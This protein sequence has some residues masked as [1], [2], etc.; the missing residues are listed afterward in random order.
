VI[1]HVGADTVDE[2]SVQD[3]ETLAAAENTRLRRAGKFTQRCQ[4]AFNRFVARAADCTA[5]AIEQ[6]ARGFVPDRG[7]NVGV[8]R[9]DQIACQNVRDFHHSARTPA[10]FIVRVHFSMS[11][12]ILAWNSSALL[13]IG[14]APCAISD[15]LTLFVFTILR[16]SPVSRATMSLGVPA[17][18]SMPNQVL[19]SKPGIPVS[20]MVGSAGAA[21]LRFALLMPSAR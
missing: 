6:R 1:E 17:G 10:A 4:R 11:I 14:S 2:R 5:H 9:L 20:A 15:S 7:G 19:A 21:A 12:L 3:I 18:A 16:S 13:P 8:A